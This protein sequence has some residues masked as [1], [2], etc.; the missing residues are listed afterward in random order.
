MVSVCLSW[1]VS[2]LIYRS[3]FSSSCV[4]ACPFPC[5][6]VFTK[7]PGQAGRVGSGGHCDDAA[8]PQ[9]LW[10]PPRGARLLS[11]KA[12]GF[13]LT[14][15]FCD[16]ISSLERWSGP[17]LIHTHCLQ[18][19][20][21]CSCPPLLPNRYPRRVPSLTGLESSCFSCRHPVPISPLL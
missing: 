4:A 3:S 1:S 11:H 14:I 12:S 20:H 18:A 13:C 15:S 16:P 19:K 6:G 10:P 8:L 17:K 5:S 21:G 9:G 2:N 7:G